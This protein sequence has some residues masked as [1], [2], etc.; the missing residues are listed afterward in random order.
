MSYTAVSLY[1]EFH[2]NEKAAIKAAF[3]VRMAQ[4][5]VPAF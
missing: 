5:V 1:H 2:G 3:I 4:N